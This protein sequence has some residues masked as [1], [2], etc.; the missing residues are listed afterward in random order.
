MTTQAE[1][2]LQSEVMLRLRAGAWPVIA[3][4]IPNSIYF[5]ARSDS[6]RSM[7][8]RV[9]NQM[10]NAGMLVPGAPDLVCLW[11]GGGAAI[12]LK[13]PKS[14]D[15]LKARPAGRPSDVQIEFA[16]R[17]A[18]LGIHHAYCDCWEQVRDRLTEWVAA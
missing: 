9:I 13:R 4:P 14:R 5:P 18:L 12:E 2:A 6:E 16:E 8:G 11:R 10:K 17:A 15:L 1:R 3:L 7:I